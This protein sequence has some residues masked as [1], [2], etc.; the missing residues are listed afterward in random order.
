MKSQTGL[1]KGLGALI[2]NNPS[3]ETSIQESENTQSTIEIEITKI[4]TNPFQPRVIF[5]PEAL[6]D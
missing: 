5:D 4:K 3:K 2:Q 1:G 6:K